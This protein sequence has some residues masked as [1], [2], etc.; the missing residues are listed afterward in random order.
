MPS[1]L[2]VDYERSKFRVSQ[3]IWTP[4]A[5]QNITT[6]LSVDDPTPT[7]SPSKPHPSHKLSTG[8]TVGIIVAAV[9]LCLLLI[10]AA[11][12]WLLWRKKKRQK[13]EKAS[14]DNIGE[15][16]EIEDTSPQKINE[17][18][19]DANTPGEVEGDDTF[20][21]HNKKHSL[22]MEGSPGRDS[23]RTEAPGTLGGVEIEGSRGGIEME[24]SMVPQMDGGQG[25]VYELPAGNYLSAGTGRE[26]GRRSLGT[27]K[28]RANSYNPPD[29]R[30]PETPWSPAS[31]SN[32]GSQRD[33]ERPRERDVRKDG[34]RAVEDT[35]TWSWRRSRLDGVPF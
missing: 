1:F 26:R 16:H 24:G 28:S 2:I 3:A 35:R 10:G 7:L 5:S 20:S 22:E 25:E 15:K 31:G 13:S 33:R 11:I 14:E 29:A 34:G 9:C 23:N 17:L 21:R 30:S 8:A 6:I 27:S 4:N 12:G 18:H 19:S 32:P